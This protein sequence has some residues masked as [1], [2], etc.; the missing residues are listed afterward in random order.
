MEIR[1]L[2]VLGIFLLCHFGLP[3]HAQV[4]LGTAQGVTTP[5]SPVVPIPQHLESPRRT[6]ET[7]LTAMDGMKDGDETQLGRAVTN[8]DLSDKSKLVRD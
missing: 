2:L 8:M 5:E 6:V 4:N 3:A 1:T 7:F